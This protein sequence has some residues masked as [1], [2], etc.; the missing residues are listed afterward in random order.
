[1]YRKCAP[2]HQNLSVFHLTEEHRWVLEANIESPGTNSCNCAN[3]EPP[4]NAEDQIW[5]NN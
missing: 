2:L 1:M 4:I 3:T 5:W